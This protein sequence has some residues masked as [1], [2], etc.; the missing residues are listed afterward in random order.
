MLDPRAPGGTYP[1]A[2]TSSAVTD[3]YSKL[4]SAT[5]RRQYFQE[6]GYLVVRKLIAAEL[7]DAA[8]KSF[9]Q[10]IKP[11]QGYLYR[12]ASANPE[13]HVFSESGFMLNSLLNFQDLDAARFPAFRSAG[14]EVVTCAALRAAVEELFGEPGKIVQ[15][16]YFEGNPETWPHQD[17]YYLD[18]K[19]SG[20]MTAAWVALED[21]HPGAGR[22]YIYPGSHR[23]DMAKNGGDFNIA[24]QHERYKVLVQSIVQRQGLERRT[25]ALAKGDILFW[26]AKTIHGSLPTT[27]PGYSRASITAHFIPGA[28]V[29]VQHQ[30]RIKP[31][32]LRQFNG[33]SIHCPKAQDRWPNRAVFWLETRFPGAW[34][35]AKRYAV[36]WVTRSAAAH[37]P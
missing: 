26:S 34:Q 21:I 30:S 14:L 11:F 18:G 29:F 12:Q 25:P 33:V 16:M 4:L 22:F 9:Q 3:T 31:L 19:P 7:C 36:K 10:E 5:A 17:T 13:R 24:F 37:D 1:I 8:R 6:Q 28:S 32:R 35:R 2:P 15:T 23:I 20:C 27:E